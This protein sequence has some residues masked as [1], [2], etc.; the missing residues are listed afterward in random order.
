MGRE[1]HSAFCLLQ[2]YIDLQSLGTKLQIVYAFALDHVKGFIYI[3]ADKQNDIDGVV[4][5]LSLDFF[6]LD[7]WEKGG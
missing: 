7:F 2:K 6:C 1:R 4:L 5:S 3:E